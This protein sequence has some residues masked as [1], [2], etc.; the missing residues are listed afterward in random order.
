[1]G[2]EVIAKCQ[3]GLTATI[4]IGG[5]MESFSSTCYFPCYC[6]SCK[7]V[8]QCNLLAKKKSCPICES[9]TIVPYDDPSLSSHAGTRVVADWNM[10]FQLGRELKLT[11]G[12]YKCPGCGQM[13]L[14]FLSSGLNWD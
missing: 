8:V 13:S 4:L 2:S 1:M 9:T 12:K 3:C 10:K 11:N 5:G 7:S 6:E 14:H